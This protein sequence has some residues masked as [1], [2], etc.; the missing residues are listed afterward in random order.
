MDIDLGNAV[1]IAMLDYN[2]MDDGGS[3]GLAELSD[4]DSESEDGF[5][6]GEN[7]EDDGW[8]SDEDEDWNKGEE[9]WQEG[10][11]QGDHLGGIFEAEAAQATQNLSAE[12]L[13][14]MWA[15]NFKADTQIT[16]TAYDKLSLAFSQLAGLFSLYVLQ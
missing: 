15:F 13:N 8:E 16:D 12:D 7:A 1:N 6:A 4:S 3:P 10:L 11:S 2:E 9:P 14:D 5:F